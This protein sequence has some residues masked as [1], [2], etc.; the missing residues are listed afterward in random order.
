[1]DASLNARNLRVIELSRP[2]KVTRLVKLASVAVM[3]IGLVGCSSVRD[4]FDT[5]QNEGPCP[6]VASLYD[7]ARKVQIDGPE[8][9]GNVGFT[10]EIQGVQGF[11]RYVEGD[12]ITMELD[13]DFAF[14][15]GPKAVGD[16]HNYQYFVSV[17]RRGRAVIEQQSFPLNVTFP[18]GSD[19]VTAK[20]KIEN[21]VIP[22]ADSSI[23][24]S[25]FEI[26]IGFEL[27]EDE[28]KFNRDGKRFRVNAGE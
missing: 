4:S 13:I 5:R 6:I 11:C 23:S 24:G 25:N 16:T 8:K 7:A 2:K 10:G 20:E 15:K 21:I 14:G 27:T 18:K 1:M 28:L 9:Y 17:T 19:R 3:A 26:L 12:P 22:R